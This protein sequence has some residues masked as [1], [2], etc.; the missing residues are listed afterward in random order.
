MAAG[1]MGRE[2]SSHQKPTQDKCWAA[3]ISSSDIMGC[4]D[5]CA[6]SCVGS[7][8]KKFVDRK[9]M[10]DYERRALDLLARKI[11]LALRM[12]LVGRTPRLPEPAGRAGVR[13]KV[14]MTVWRRRGSGAAAAG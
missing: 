6:K 7:A 5:T 2:I 4:S 12:T 9:A 10:K 3:F 1:S 14:C 8:A 13:E 11:F